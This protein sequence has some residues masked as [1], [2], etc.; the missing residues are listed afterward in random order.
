[1]QKYKGHSQEKFV[2]QCCFGGRLEDLVLCGSEDGAIFI[3]NKMHGTLLTSIT[4][5]IGPVNVLSWSP[6]NSLSFIS[7]GD[8]HVVKVWSLDR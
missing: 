4:G 7:G 8:D 6:L 3:W 2:L 1:M 5:H